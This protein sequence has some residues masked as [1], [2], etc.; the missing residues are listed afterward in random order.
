MPRGLT[1]V[2]ETCGN[3]VK[4]DADVDARNRGVCSQPF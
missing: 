1:K 2:D 3:V 4:I